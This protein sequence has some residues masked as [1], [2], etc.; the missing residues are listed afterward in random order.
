MLDFKCVS[1][2]IFFRESGGK[3]KELLCCCLLLRFNVGFRSN[4]VGNNHSSS[5]CFLVF[6]H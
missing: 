1:L 4:D 6:T 2:K 3:N 5:L